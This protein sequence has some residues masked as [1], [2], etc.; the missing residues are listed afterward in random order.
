LRVLYLTYNGLTEPLGRR[1]VLPYVLGLAARGWRFTVVSF[2]KT[3]TADDPAR[4]QVARL[5]E[6]AHAEWIP[7]RYHKRP[8]MA[9]TSFDAAHGIATALRYRGRQADPRAST[10]PLD[11]GGG[12]RPPVPGSS[13]F[14][15]SPRNTRTAG[16]ELPGLSSR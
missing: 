2:E 1:Q 16:T 10:V 7:R 15:L 11:G 5:L 6:E 12:G 9:A 4:E 14:R 13:T 3:E 8:T